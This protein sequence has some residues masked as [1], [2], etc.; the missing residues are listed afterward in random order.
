MPVHPFTHPFTV[1]FRREPFTD[2]ADLHGSLVRPFTDPFT[3][4]T[5]PDLHARSLFYRRE[6]VSGEAFLVTM[7]TPERTTP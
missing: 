5:R 4:F 6:R 1:P 7:T 2:P 3:P